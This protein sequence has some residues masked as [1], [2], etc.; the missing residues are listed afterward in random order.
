MNDSPVLGGIHRVDDLEAARVALGYDRID[1][2]SESA[3]TRTAMIYAWRY[4]QSIHRSVM[5]GVNPPGNFL[6][7]PA[8]T[9]QQIH[10]YAAL[11]AG[12]P[13]CSGRTGDLAA[14]LCGLAV[15]ERCQPLQLRHRDGA[16]ER[17]DRWLSI[18]VNLVGRIPGLAKNPVYE[19]LTD[20]MLAVVKE[21]TKPDSIP[22]LEAMMPTSALVRLL[23]RKRDK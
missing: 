12:D 10:R 4:P 5:I 21:G 7:N 6:W 2:L 1:L 17:L 18:I 16:S 9:D 15:L 19:L 14:T 11:C 3:G 20:L 23:N 13:S 8:V 22:G